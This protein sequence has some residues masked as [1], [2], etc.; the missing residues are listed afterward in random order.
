[1]FLLQ[2]LNGS[3]K[4]LAWNY[5]L[6]YSAVFVFIIYHNNILSKRS[7]ENNATVTVAYIITVVIK[8]NPVKTKV[9]D[10]KFPWMDFS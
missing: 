4:C 3:S 6:Q 10:D 2:Q 5:F 7:A 9:F 8:H 1:M